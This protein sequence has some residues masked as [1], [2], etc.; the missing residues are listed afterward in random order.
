[1]RNK[2]INILP[3]CISLTIILIAFVVVLDEPKTVYEEKVHVVWTREEAEQLHSPYKASFE[4]AV[5]KTSSAQQSVIKVSAPEWIRTNDNGLVNYAKTPTLLNCMFIDKL[6]PIEI[7]EVVKANQKSYMKYQALGTESWNRQGWL[8]RCPAAYTDERGIRCVDGR[9]LIAVGSYYCDTIGTYMDVFLEDGTIIP[10][11]MGD[12][13]A[14]KDT[15][16]TNRYAGDKSVIEFVIDAPDGY[17][18][19][20][21]IYPETLTGNYSVYPEYQSVVVGLRIYEKVY[22]IQLGGIN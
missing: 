7:P 9:K 12:M 17:A 16:R 15:D 3:I 1:M 20:Q 11:M 14:D 6:A 13:K 5:H 4:E 21:K 10:C 2:L 8:S 18:A 19:F 22:D